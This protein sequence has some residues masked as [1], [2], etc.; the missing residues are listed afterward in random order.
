MAEPDLRFFGERVDGIR[1]EA[2][3]LRAL[4][5]DVALLAERTGRLEKRGK[6][7]LRT[8]RAGE[9]IKRRQ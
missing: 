6:S 3:E 2:R 5:I 4:T 7:S 9:A 1:T 8:R